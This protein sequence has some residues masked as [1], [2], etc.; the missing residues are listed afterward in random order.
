M[1]IHRTP[2]TTPGV[3]TAPIVGFAPSYVSRSFEIQGRKRAN[4]PT[5]H[6]V[7]TAAQLAADRKWLYGEAPSSTSTTPRKAAAPP[8]WDPAEGRA[9]FRELEDWQVAPEVR[10]AAQTMLEIATEDLGLQP[11][12]LRW[13]EDDAWNDLG[14]AHW[15]RPRAIW[16]RKRDSNLWRPVMRVVAHELCHLAQFKAHGAAVGWGLV[17]DRFE[18]DAVAYAR[19]MMQRFL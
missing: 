19:E 1:T 18:A 8:A 14:F 17:R 9:G 2:A 13:Y 10:K 6:V 16:V 7:D 4:R 3:R 12:T 5:T 15:E 11:I